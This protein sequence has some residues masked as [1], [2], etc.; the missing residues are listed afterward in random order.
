MRCAHCSHSTLRG[1]EFK[2]N[3]G[4]LVR[5]CPKKGRRE[6]RE[7]R[8]LWEEGREKERGERRKQRKSNLA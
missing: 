4:Y 3:L 2:L 6:G 1:R 7:G 5:S 8:E